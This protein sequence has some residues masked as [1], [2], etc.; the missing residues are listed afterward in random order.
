VKRSGP[1][2]A[3][4]DESIRGHLMGCVLIEAK[5]LARLRADVELLVLT[6]GRV[7]FHNESTGRRRDILTRFAEHP[8]SAFVVVCHGT[9]A[10]A[11]SARARIV[12]LDHRRAPPQSRGPASCARESARR[13]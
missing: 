1:T 6:G 3:F 11:S 13:H 7:H 12:S 4:V 5:Y 8:M 10:S 9:T 2:D